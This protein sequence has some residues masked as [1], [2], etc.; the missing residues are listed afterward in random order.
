MWVVI[1]YHFIRH[2]TH[3]FCLIS[4][5]TRSVFQ[6]RKQAEEWKLSRVLRSPYLIFCHQYSLILPS[7]LYFC[8]WLLA[9]AVQLS[10]GQ[11]VSCCAISCSD[12]VAPHSH[13]QFFDSAVLAQYICHSPPFLSSCFSFSPDLDLCLT[14]AFLFPYNNE[15]FLSCCYPLKPG[16]C[17]LQSNSW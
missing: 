12:S 3:C 8:L 15:S 16:I 4:P 6:R 9:N 1:N 11:P 14:A 5:C 13:W 7:R 17:F 10:H 2:W